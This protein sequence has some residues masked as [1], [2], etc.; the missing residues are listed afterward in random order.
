MEQIEKRILVGRSVD[1]Y[2]IVLN[3]LN[4]ERSIRE[5]RYKNN[6]NKN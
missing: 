5:E 1:K 6:A 2:R 4:Y 3:L